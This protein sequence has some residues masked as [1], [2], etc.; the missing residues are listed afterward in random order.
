MNFVLFLP[1]I[2]SFVV[3][4][5]FLPLWIRKS[6]QIGLLWDDMNKIDK[7]RVSG[8]GGIVVL[9]AFILGVLSYVALKTFVL[10]INVTGIYIFALLST[11]IIASMVGFVDDLFGWVRGGLSARLRLILIFMAAIPLMVINAGFSKIEIPFIGIVN[12]GI[13]YAL[14]FIPI[15]II[16]VTT[17]YNFLAGFNGLEAGQGIIIIS[18]LSFVSY[19][20]GKSWL[21]LIG[22]CMV[23]SLIVFFAYNKF[24]ARVFPGD[25]M[26][27]AIGSLIACMAILGNFE[28]IAV[29]VFLPYILEVGLKLRGRL[30]KYSFGR[31]QTDGS[32]EEPFNKIYGLEH[33]AIRILKRLKGKVYE[34]DVT[35]LILSFQII[36]CLL[37]LLIFKGGLF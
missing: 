18:F 7:P 10:N 26:T 19:L 37:S 25:V 23:A 8:S 3:T 30:R 21:A 28:R 11:I 34:R 1:V 24:P 32:I 2:I 4:L 14:I 29:F 31:P 9:M 13:L 6:K 16:G 15:G 35:Y 36:I 20:L 33:L 12:V 22:L 27:Y 5:V 17:T